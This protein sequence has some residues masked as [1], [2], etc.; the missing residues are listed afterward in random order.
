MNELFKYLL[1]VAITVEKACWQL[2]TICTWFYE[3]THTYDN[4]KKRKRKKEDKNTETIEDRIKNRKN[5][6]K[7]TGKLSTEIL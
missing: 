3:N 7:V 6:T 1:H 5:T 4:I 2:M